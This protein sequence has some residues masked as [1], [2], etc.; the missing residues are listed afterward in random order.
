MIQRNPT[1]EHCE[2]GISS[3]SFVSLTQVDL[4]ISIYH[5][6]VRTYCAFGA[7]VVDCDSTI[8]DDG[9]GGASQSLDCF[10]DPRS[11]SVCL[12]RGGVA[13][14]ADV[15]A[16]T[17]SLSQETS[18]D[19]G[20]PVVFKDRYQHFISITIELMRGMIEN[21]LRAFV[22]LSS[23]CRDGNDCLLDVPFVAAAQ[24]R[25]MEAKGLQTLDRSWSRSITE[26]KNG[27]DEDFGGGGRADG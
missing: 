3:Q 15:P 19:F 21:F 10:R 13:I 1:V 12:P 9:G 24:L 26:F 27:K 4:C 17:M 20:G 25:L 16:V 22:L 8:T 18:A 2:C 5:L 23:V 6:A 11:F 14:F 7:H